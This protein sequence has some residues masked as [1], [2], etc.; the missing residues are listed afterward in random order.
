MGL[1]TTL[2]VL[3]FGIALFVIANFKSRR[4]PPLGTVRMVPYT[5]LQFIALVIVIVTLG[6]LVS[7][8]TGQPLQGRFTR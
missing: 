4:P 3:G 5:G 8:L 6:H 2:A 7:L 1:E